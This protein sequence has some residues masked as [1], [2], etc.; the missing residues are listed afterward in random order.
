MELEHLN[1]LEKKL[2]INMFLGVEV[3][4]SKGNLTAEV[5]NKSMVTIS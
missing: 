2:T 4:V 3:L 1:Y 5:Q